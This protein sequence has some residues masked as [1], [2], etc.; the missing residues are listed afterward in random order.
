MD[1]EEIKKRIEN[2]KVNLTGS[3]SKMMKDLD[4]AT[5]PESIGKVEIDGKIFEFKILRNA[6]VVIA[7]NSMEE[8]KSLVTKKLKTK[9]K[10]L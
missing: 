4:E 8:A 5:V 3:I 10:W 9:K 1:A 6:S 2:V 7:M